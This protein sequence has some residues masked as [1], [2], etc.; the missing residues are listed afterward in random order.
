MLNL[1]KRG[2]LLRT[3]FKVTERR[4]GP[5]VVP[6]AAADLVR[7]LKIRVTN[8]KIQTTHT[9]WSTQAKLKCV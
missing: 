9:C 7:Q 1:S 3:N 4:K 6:R 2:Q 5:K 8:V